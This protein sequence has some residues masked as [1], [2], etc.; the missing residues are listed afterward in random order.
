VEER[1]ETDQEVQDRLA[2]A[3][4]DAGA[5]T[6]PKGV[7]DGAGVLAGDGVETLRSKLRARLANGPPVGL[8]RPGPQPPR[9]PL[10]PLGRVGVEARRARSSL[11]RV[12]P[13]GCPRT[14]FPG[15]VD[16][17]KRVLCGARPS[18]RSA[19]GLEV[20]RPRCA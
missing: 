12:P 4:A 8:Q 14:G 19:V 11:E 5:R 10:Q 6:D 20:H 17:T 9:R 15:G 13:Y 3:D 18:W 1:L 2:V 16:V 7:D